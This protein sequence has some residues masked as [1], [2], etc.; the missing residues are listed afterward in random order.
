[1]RALQFGE[2]D[3]CASASR[4]REPDIAQHA[5]LA[6]AA[7]SRACIGASSS[8]DARAKL[9]RRCSR[10][11]SAGTR[12]STATSSS[13]SAT[14]IS[15]ARMISLRATSMPD[16][17]SRG[18]GLGVALVDGVAQHR[19]ERLLAVPDVEEI[20]QRARQDAFDATDVVAGLAQVAQRLDHR[21]RRADRRFVEKMRAARR[22]GAWCSS[23]EEGEPG[24]CPPACSA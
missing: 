24:R 19:G 3:R 10:A 13:S 8:L 18:I 11:A 1:M 12:P 14:P 5:A 6:P 17:S 15:R 2:T 23:F 9:A 21:Q 16:R 20:G 22:G 4:H 7:A